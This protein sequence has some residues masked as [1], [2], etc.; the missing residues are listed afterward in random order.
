MTNRQP[1]Q[2]TVLWQGQVIAYRLFTRRRSV[3]IG[4]RKGVTFVT[5][6]LSGFPHRFRLLSPV[7][8]GARLRVGPGMTGKLVLRGKER[9]VQDL[10]AESAPRRL[11]GN[12]GMFRET[13]LYPGDSATIELDDDSKLRLLI[14]FSDPADRVPRPRFLPDPLLVR[15]TIGTAAML[16]LLLAG[17]TILSDRLQT[18]EQVMTQDR[19]AKV[20]L[21]TPPPPDPEEKRRK[22]AEA[23]KLAEAARRRM[24]KEA[25]ESKKAQKQEGRI[26]REDA[27]AKET[28]IPKGREDILRAK[29][30]R[31]GVLAVLGNHRPPGSGLAKLFD[32]SDKSDVEQ[33]MNGL[34]GVE[35]TAGRGTGGLG[36]IGS[37]PGGGG[38]S[39]G[40]I[41][42]SGSLD[43]GAGRGRGRKGPSLG[44]GREREVQ[45]GMETGTADT[46]GGLTREQVNRV[47]KA[48][49]SAIRYCYEKELQR[50][51]SLAGKVELF[52]VIKA[53][54]TV[55]R[56]KVANSTLGSR[57]VEGCMERQVR[58]WQFPRSDSETIVQSY[59]FFF[60]GTQ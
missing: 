11:L 47:V 18:D 16:T 35:L 28:V 51:P 52:W 15:S 46:E 39:F 29:V 48:H 8:D 27:V 1:L 34:V 36:S 56:I 5:P 25:A 10:L 14:T 58:N 32:T 50:A 9:S 40:R 2:V 30:A 24:E 31:S 6:V 60:R 4:D 53:N 23:R 55:D 13:E 7:R 3:S 43:V 54:G 20:A 17:L 49:A 12:P 41:Q 38:T 22:E 21:L 37:G 26:G 45:V 19:V 42:G 44:K 57:A 59:P 33:A